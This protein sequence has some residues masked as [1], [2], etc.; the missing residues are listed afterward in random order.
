M[1]AQKPAFRAYRAGDEK[2]ILRLPNCGP[3]SVS[4]LEEWS[5][6]FPVE[7]YGRLIVVGERGGEVVAVCAGR[8][9]RVQMHD[10]EWAAVDLHHVAAADE[11]DLPRSVEAFFEVQD[12]ENRFA[13]ILATHLS[14]ELDHAGF[15]A[16]RRSHQ[17]IVRQQP[18]SVPLARL[19]YRA[20]PARDW[21]PRLD[22]LWQRARRS[23]PCAVVRDG[24]RALRCFAAHPSIRH[25]RFL[26]CPRF[27][28]RAV[29]AAVF[30]LEGDRLR[31]ADLVW[32]HD[33]PGALGLL[34]FLSAN[35]VGQL[36]AAGEELWLVGDD[37]TSS[38]LVKAGFSPHEPVFAPVLAARS[39]VPELDAA[40]FVGRAYLT[41]SDVT[42]VAL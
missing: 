26:V 18:S 38:R 15:V 41:L 40:E 24:D 21:E 25:H 16:A 1:M 8:P 4:T 32:D 5:W 31:W 23:Y 42:A 39:F 2:A 29:A 34:S 30:T 6:R 7:E 28:S 19:F 20:E 14:D 36:G 37:E 12:I 22:E 35:L 17:V 33:H 9:I 10:R 11:D 3:R 13:L 27:S